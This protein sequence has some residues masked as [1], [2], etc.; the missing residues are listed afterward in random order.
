MN[1][2][3]FKINAAGG[4]M[5]SCSFICRSTSSLERHSALSLTFFGLLTECI[6]DCRISF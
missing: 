6:F 5:F 1:V 4:Y 3:S 2:V